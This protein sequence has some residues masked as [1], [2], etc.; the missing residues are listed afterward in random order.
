MVCLILALQYGGSTYSWSAP[1]IIGLLVTFSVL[2]IAFVVVKVLTPETAMAPTRVVLN[3]S[4]ASNM[5][6]MFLLSRGLMSAVY[7]LTV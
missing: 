5:T 4:I 7:H 2:F 6:F 3:R 1:K